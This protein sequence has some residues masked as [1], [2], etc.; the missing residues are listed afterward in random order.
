MA[1]P[2]TPDEMQQIKA[3]KN[4]L[5][6]YLKKARHDGSPSHKS[7]MSAGGGGGGRP[8]TSLDATPRWQAA[9]ESPDSH[10]DGILSPVHSAR[11]PSADMSAASTVRSSSDH[12][13]GAV[14]HQ[15]TSYTA[16]QKQSLGNGVHGP[17]ADGVSAAQATSTDAQ[18]AALH[19]QQRRANDLEQSLQEASAKINEER[20]ARQA[21]AAE[22]E[23][24]RGELTRLM[25]HNAQADHSGHAAVET[26][27]AQATAALQEQVA[28]IQSDLDQ[29]NEAVRRL[30][31]EKNMLLEQKESRERIVVRARDEIAKTQAQY[32]AAQQENERLR[33]QINMLAAERDDFSAALDEHRVAAAE[34]AELV[35]A[36]AELREGH[37]KQTDEHLALQAECNKLRRAYEDANNRAETHAA[38]VKQL[39][40]ILAAERKTFSQ[41]SDEHAQLSANEAERR[42]ELVSQARANE[43]MLERATEQNTELK[44]RLFELEDRFVVISN[45]RLSLTN[46]VDALRHRLGEPPRSTTTTA[47][48]HA[49]LS[50]LSRDTSGSGTATPGSHALGTPLRGTPGAG[51]PSAESRESWPL[52]Q[53][54]VDQL[55]L[56]IHQLEMERDELLRHHQASSP[57]SRDAS[58]TSMTA[59][60]SR[61]RPSGAGG[62]GGSGSGGGAGS[63]SRATL[64]ELPDGTVPTTA[65]VFEVR[66]AELE[67][68]VAN[69]EHEKAD[70]VARLDHVNEVNA[71]LSQRLRKEEEL[72]T[73]LAK[74]TEKIPE[75][76]IIY[77]QQRQALDRKMQEQEELLRR[78][79]Q[80]A[81]IQGEPLASMTTATHAVHAAQ[82]PHPQQHQP[83]Q[84]TP[85]QQT[86]AVEERE[87][88]PL[89]PPR[90]HI[91]TPELVEPPSRSYVQAAYIYGDDGVVTE[92]PTQPRGPSKAQLLAQQHR[93]IVSNPWSHD[94][95]I[96]VL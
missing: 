14:T 23:R 17:Q 83:P 30:Q 77:Q 96:F 89:T 76:I 72:T 62:S 12:G 13:H 25:A 24:L 20:A 54:L 28:T 16:S 8:T 92:E 81:G 60:P 90:V 21:S 91:P 71:D 45:E 3:G 87:P 44:S 46:E 15:H 74:E 2:R 68:E 41:A 70:L 75:L 4:R 95:G 86:V 84:D 29:A 39:E 61:P 88:K 37:K 5:K 52:G 64:P 55:Y 69:L 51:T 38:Q 53:D 48:S 82:P 63:R 47:S 26:A 1:T 58:N 34:H 67:E 43:A 59:S 94:S 85:Q 6:K 22:A 93:Q 19:E 7:P 57:S 18:N 11:P 31:G 65:A 33:A 42:S 78:A 35:S 73:Q 66:I 32:K 10:P 49:P 40:S 79:W 80:T 36:V 27:V 50:S 56:Q 9:I